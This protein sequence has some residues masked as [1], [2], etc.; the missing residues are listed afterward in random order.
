MLEPLSPA[1]YNCCTLISRLLNIYEMIMKNKFITSALSR[2]WKDSNIHA[3]YELCPAHTSLSCCRRRWSSFTL[4]WATRCCLL[5]SPLRS[6]LRHPK[7][8][9]PAA[10][11]GTGGVSSSAGQRVGDR[12]TAPSALRGRNTKQRCRQL[13]FGPGLGAGSRNREQDELCQVNHFF[14]IPPFWQS[15]HHLPVPATGAG[16][17]T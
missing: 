1:S 14:P 13:L 2:A 7:S 17:G 16:A 11:E 10:A 4:S 8:C 12:R 6:P 9:S 15:Q 3:D 5:R